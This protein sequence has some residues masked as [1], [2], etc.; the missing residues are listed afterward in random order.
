MS[1][2]VLAIESKEIKRMNHK[3][4]TQWAQ[5]KSLQI[6]E[7]IETAVE[8]AEV[9][10]RDAE[11]AKSIEI[12][13]YQS[14]KKKVDAT[15]D[16]LVKA[17]EAIADL[18]NLVKE[19]IQFSQ[20]NTSLSNAVQKALSKMIAE[21]ITDANG[22]VRNVSEGATQFV[23]KVQN[24]ASRFAAR[25]RQVE[26]LQAEHASKVIELQQRS[27][28]AD[29]ALREELAELESHYTAN[30]DKLSSLI[31]KKVQ[32]V[33]AQ[34]AENDEV[35][36]RLLAELKARNAELSEKSDAN[37][38]DHTRLLSEL[39]AKYDTLQA[40]LEAQKPSLLPIIVSLL[41]FGLGAAS[42]LITLL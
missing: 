10:K 14:S 9:A 13:W 19:A 15:S 4:L 36:D 22:Q 23:E 3:Q 25:Q 29:E 11:D 7:R 31:D 16:A 20:T 21:G 33:H 2:A 37:D 18:H 6:V 17:N 28:Q 5:Q 27:E 12:K 26:Q 1:N 30:L 35:H 39:G 42:L 32:E 41:A 8:R 38:A 24:E 34:S 40:Q